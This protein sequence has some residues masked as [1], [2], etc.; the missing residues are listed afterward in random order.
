MINYVV[1]FAFY[2]TQDGD[3]VVLIRKNRPEYMKG[4]WNGVG[5]KIE[6]SE[7]PVESMTR[8]FKEE[9]GLI[10]APARWTEY[11][12]ITGPDYR[13]HFFMTELDEETDFPRS[14]TDEKVAI[15]PCD[16]LPRTVMFNL[17]WLIPMAIDPYLDF[18]GLPVLLENHE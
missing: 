4:R 15:Y 2:R 17:N 8:E 10:V 12:N 11:C 6:P 14:M 3:G 9:T 16:G 1:G 5:G 18:S 7:L 13:I